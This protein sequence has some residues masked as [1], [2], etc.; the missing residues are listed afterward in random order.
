MLTSALRQAKDRLAHNRQLCFWP[1]LPAVHCKHFTSSATVKCP[2]RPNYES[3]T[4]G[5]YCVKMADL[6]QDK[7]DIITKH[8]LNGALD[9]LREALHKSRVALQM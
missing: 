9:S 2:V 4:P 7:R 5:A 1:F 6:S 8:P 3:M